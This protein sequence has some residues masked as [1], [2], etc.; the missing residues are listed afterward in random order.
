MSIKVTSWIWEHSGQ[1][2]AA[3][4]LLLAIGDHAHDDGRG[5]YPST[6]ALA[7]KIRMTRRNTQLL[8]RK[9]EQSGELVVST[10]TGP[11]GTNEYTIPVPWSGGE[12]FTPLKTFQGEKSGSRGAKNSRPSKR[13][14]VITDSPEPSSKPSIEPSSSGG[15]GD[16]AVAGQNQDDDRLPFQE[17]AT[18][19]PDRLESAQYLQSV[20]VADM[21]VVARLSVHP[22]A[23]LRARWAQVAVGGDP[24]YWPGRL[25]KSL[26]DKPPTATEGQPVQPAPAAAPAVDDS[27]RPAWMDPADWAGLTSVQREAY[28]GARLAD[29]G[30]IIAA[31]DDLQAQIDT[32]FR[33]TTARLISTYH[34]RRA[35]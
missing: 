10:G 8:I 18:P 28:A 30:R 31:F 29:D 35:A 33:T 9:V 32:R 25:V 2:G 11:H 22:V 5:A 34:E 19:D 7:A 20:G 1:K 4:L 23:A 21:G 14:G 6:D 26:R 15:D 24:K 27:Q 3:L 17:M 16:A 12:K 13:G